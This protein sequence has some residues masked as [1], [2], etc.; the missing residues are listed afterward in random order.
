M[1]HRIMRMPTYYGLLQYSDYEPVKG[2]WEPL[3]S[4]MKWDELQKVLDDKSKP[5]VTKHNHAYRKL[6]TCPRCGLHI[7]PYTKFKNGHKY[8][9]YG[10][11]KRNGNCGNPPVTLEQLEQ[12][13]FEV[14]S[15]VSIDQDILSQLKEITR[16]KLEEDYGFEISKVNEAEVRLNVI[17]KNLDQLL[18]MR[19]DGEL[20]SEEYMTAKAKLTSEKE[21][22]ESVRSSVRVN[23]DDVR[24][25]L[26]LFLTR[27]LTCRMYL[28]MGL[29]TRR[30]E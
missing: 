15:S 2:K 14:V 23:R 20:T 19:V 26:E 9:Y 22:H 4:K 8:T 6:L 25:Q 29:W 12:Q 10:C 18:Q 27:L 11:S 17:S 13:L 3:I 24:N 5:S 7:V 30:V 28:P 16:T 1:V 21:H